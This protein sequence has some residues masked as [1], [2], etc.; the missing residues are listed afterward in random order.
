[1]LRSVMLSLLALLSWQAQAAYQ[2]EVNPQDDIFITPQQVQVVGASG[3]LVI[4]PQGD[5]TRNQTA[6][7][8]T[9]AQRQQA[10]AYQANLRQQLPWIEQAA[11]AHLEK[12]RV[13]LDGVI[14]K[15]L[16]SD[17]NVRAR[18]T[19]LD[20][21]LK[22]QMARILEPRSDGIAFHHKAVKQ[23]EQDGRQLVQQALGGVLQDS[24][25]EMGV[26]Q[27]SSGG[28]PLQAMMGNLGNLQQAIQTEWNSQEL[29]FQRFGK[30]VCQR[31]IS[32]ENQRKQ[33]LK[34]LP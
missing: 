28:N 5:V 31:V 27:L 3:N 24:L 34:S 21:Q 26:K 15:E 8:L 20:T 16:G 2:C 14:A 7:T 18:L 25:N 1:M 29:T 4:S 9:A 23:V 32:L 11:Q 33:L 6:V 30:D 22:Q 10:K 12:A 17:S 13:A 19:T